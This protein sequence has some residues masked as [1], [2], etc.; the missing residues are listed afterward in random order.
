MWYNECGEVRDVFDR[1]YGAVYG[2]T[3]WVHVGTA[4]ALMRHYRTG[5]YSH[6]TWKLKELVL[7]DEG[8]VAY[9]RL[10]EVE[11]KIDDTNHYILGWLKT[12]SMLHNRE[13]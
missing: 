3:R 10:L 11:A 7:E 12:E 9:K 13:A 4:E 5:L 2:T 1:L 6:L 8:Q